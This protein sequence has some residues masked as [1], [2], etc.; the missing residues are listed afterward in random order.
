M[1]YSELKEEEN[2]DGRVK[3]IW[4]AAGEE[5]MIVRHLHKYISPLGHEG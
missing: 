4:M 5:A 2:E 1:W 3:K